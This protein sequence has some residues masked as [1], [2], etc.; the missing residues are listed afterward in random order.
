VQGDQASIV[1]GAI[2]YVKELEQL[3]QSLE[4]H[5]R[6]KQDL[7]SISS[8]HGNPTRT[9]STTNRDDEQLRIFG[10]FFNFPQYS[11]SNQAISSSNC[12]NIVSSN[13]IEVTMVDGHASVKILAEKQNK[14]L[15][16]L[17]AAFQ[18]LGL[19]VLHLNLTTLHPFVLYSFNLKVCPLSLPFISRIKA[20]IVLFLFFLK[21]GN[22]FRVKMSYF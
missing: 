1:G 10:D 21:K 15:L 22:F 11:S 4:A 5:K 2:N 18:G 14:Q 17:V 8:S 19:S 20:F 12:N 7:D 9:N 13:D 3:L 6:S 16:K